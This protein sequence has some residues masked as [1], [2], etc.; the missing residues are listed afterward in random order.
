MDAE[1][2]EHEW[3]MPMSLLSGEGSEYRARLLDGGLFIA[4]GRKTREL[5]TVYIQTAH[6]EARALCVSRIGWNGANFVLP[7][8]TIGPEGGEAVLFQTPYEA[9]QLLNVAGTLEE[10]QQKVGRFCS[11][12]SRLILAA[13]CAFAGPV[14]ALAGEESGGVHLVGPSSIG[15]STAQIVGG[16]VLGGGGRDGFLQSWR[17]T[18]NGLEAVAALHNDM[19]LYLD[20]LA[21]LEPRE[22]SEIAYLLANGSGKQRMNRGTGARKKL[23]W[24]LIFV[25]G[26]EITL[27]EHAQTVGKRVRAGGEV[28]LLNIQADAGAKMGI[29]ENIHGARDP[30]AFARQLKRAALRYYGAPLRVWLEFLTK[31]QS[32]AKTALRKIRIDFRKKYL[33]SG[34]SG[35]VSRAAQR[36]ALI[37]AA[38]ELATVAGIT[39]WAEGESMVA[40][41]QCFQSWLKN[42]GTTGP[43]DMEAAVRQV[44]ML[45]Q[46]HGVPRF[47]LI[48]HDGNVHKDQV[49]RDQAGFRRK[50]DAGETEFLIFSEIFKTEFCK[51]YSWQAIAKELLSR[52]YLRRAESHNTIKVRLPGLKN[53]VR[54]YCVRETI[55]KGDA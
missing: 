39:G 40:A 55:L 22:A 32:A 9:E 24:S 12:N 28:R 23:T 8:S 26:G 38:G 30:D 29:F 3:A 17:A 36:F 31:D 41:A 49:V 6:P 34:A 5:L 53:P 19:C 54:V 10:W 47:P 25:S 52:G 7:G 27:S 43:A 2:K 33:P 15:K 21:Q 45:L 18:A 1:G 20:E 16:S 14:L 35:E 50:T 48:G 51:G 13:S 11:G 44:R 4:P 42:R 37:G 46:A